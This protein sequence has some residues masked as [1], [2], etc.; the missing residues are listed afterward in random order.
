MQ[1]NDLS[2]LN[3]GA[4]DATKREFPA[5]AS[6]RLDANEPSPAEMMDGGRR[7]LFCKQSLCIMAKIKYGGKNE[8]AGPRSALFLPV[9]G[10]G[11][12]GF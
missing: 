5:S 11:G 7:S 2:R 10:V 1:K 3:D 12:G 4:D 6:R 8:M 9:F